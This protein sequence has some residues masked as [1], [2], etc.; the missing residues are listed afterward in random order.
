MVLEEAAALLG[1]LEAEGEDVDVVY[2][3]N[4]CLGHGEVVNAGIVLVGTACSDVA[5]A[6]EC[7]AGI[8]LDID[9]NSLCRCAVV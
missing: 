3:H 2:A 5:A 9:G 1:F 4:G 8:S 6:V 7:A